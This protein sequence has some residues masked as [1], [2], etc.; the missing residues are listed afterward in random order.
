LTFE[1]PNAGTH[2]SVHSRISPTLDPAST[3]A[4]DPR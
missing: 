3:V 4:G 1:A 2:S